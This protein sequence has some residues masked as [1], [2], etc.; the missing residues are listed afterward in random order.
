MLV[1]PRGEPGQGADPARMGERGRKT[2]LFA[3]KKTETAAERVCP[4]LYQMTLNDFKSS[5]WMYLVPNSW[6]LLLF[7]RMG[8]DVISL[9]ALSPTASLPSAPCGPPWLPVL[10]PSCTSLKLFSLKEPYLHPAFC[11]FF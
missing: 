9:S 1:L 7:G 10:A 2:P 8:I 4:E 5:N 3:T 6:V 11:L